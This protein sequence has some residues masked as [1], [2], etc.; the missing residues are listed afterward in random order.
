[1]VMLPQP[2]VAA[3]VRAKTGAVA[4]WAAARRGAAAISSSATAGR[5]T[6]TA[7]QTKVRGSVSTSGPPGAGG[8]DGRVGD[9]GVAPSV[10]SGSLLFGAIVTTGLWDRLPRR[11]VPARDCR[12]GA[13]PLA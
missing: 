3:W 12:H 8:S 7:S 6:A 4:K 1:M 9:G 11:A 5:P 2:R 10:T 13:R